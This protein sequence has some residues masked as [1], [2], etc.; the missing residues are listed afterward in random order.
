MVCNI[1]GNKERARSP[2]LLLV[3]LIFG[4]R[5][6]WKIGGTWKPTNHQISIIQFRKRYNPNNVQYICNILYGC[7]S[8]NTA[9]VNLDSG[10]SIDH[11]MPR[12]LLASLVLHWVKYYYP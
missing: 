1:R 4:P 5:P 10:R 6:A 3:R 11:Y 7:V 12:I 2:M 9:V 8:T